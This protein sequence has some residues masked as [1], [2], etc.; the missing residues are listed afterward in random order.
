MQKWFNGLPSG[1]MTSFVQIAELFR[2]HFIA[3]KRERRTCIEIRQSKEDDLKYYVMRFYQKGI[4][5][6]DRQDGV[7]YIPFLNG[8]PLM[9]NKITTLA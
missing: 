7:A 1:I 4:L 6:P 3:N 5:I 2:A 9:E 8:L